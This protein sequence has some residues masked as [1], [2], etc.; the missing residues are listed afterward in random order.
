PGDADPDTG[1][2]IL[3]DGVAKGR[4]IGEH[5]VITNVRPGAYVVLA[6]GV[7][8]DAEIQDSTIAN[9]STGQPERVDLTLR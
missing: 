1:I 5:M 3:L 6:Q 7:K 8:G 9:V 4:L 2:T